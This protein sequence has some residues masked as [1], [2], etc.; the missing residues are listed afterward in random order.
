MPTKTV[1]TDDTIKIFENKKHDKRIHI[2]Y[3]QDVT[4]SPITEDETIKIAFIGISNHFKS[5]NHEHIPSFGA[6]N[7]C[8]VQNANEEVKD[9]MKRLFEHPEGLTHAWLKKVIKTLREAGVI[10][11]MIERHLHGDVHHYAQSIPK[12]PTKDQ[13]DMSLAGLVYIK[14]NDIEPLLGK[15]FKELNTEILEEIREKM[16]VVLGIH[17]QYLN[18]EVYDVHITNCDE[19]EYESCFEFYGLN[20][21]IEDFEEMKNE[22]Y[23]DFIQDELP[24]EALNPEDWE[25]I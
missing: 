6:L 24:E 21:E 19:T 7:D 2:C 14:E 10:A 4:E 18:G 3:S 5:P 13:F 16:N 8:L 22:P 1:K 15:P 9:K 23:W 12:P 25:E 20:T 11:F 17:D